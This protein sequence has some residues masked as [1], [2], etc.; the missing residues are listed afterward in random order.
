[1]RNINGIT[2]TETIEFVSAAEAERIRAGQMLAVPAQLDISEVVQIRVAPDPWQQAEKLTIR[3]HRRLS[4]FARWFLTLDRATPLLIS[5]DDI[6]DLDCSRDT[7]WPINPLTRLN[8]GWYDPTLT[9]STTRGRATVALEAVATV[10]EFGDA[11]VAVRA[12]DL[13]L[14]APNSPSE[15][16][17]RTALNRVNLEEI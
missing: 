3:E 12:T 13:M 4:E 11:I 1:M 5:S 15:K 10:P 16:F 6:I 7:R 17:A 8:N 2:P 14:S 9:R